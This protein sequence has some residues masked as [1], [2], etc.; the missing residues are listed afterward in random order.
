[1]RL[2]SSG[3][4][5]RTFLEADENTI[6]RRPNLRRFARDNGVEY[7]VMDG[8]WVINKEQFFKV[9]NPKKV[10]MRETM[11]RMRTKQNAVREWNDAHQRVK[12]DKH[13]VD[14]CMQD[15]SVFKLKRNNVWL[16]NYDQ[17][18]P[19]IVAFMKEHE[20]IPMEKRMQKKKYPNKG[21]K[22]ASKSE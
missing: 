16:I 5:W 11:P 14:I 17:L 8:K 20:Y 18:L 21:R 19:I 15:K 7:Y 4:I 3:D 22:R 9:I 12:I 6:I 13:I 1:M 10:S 2:V